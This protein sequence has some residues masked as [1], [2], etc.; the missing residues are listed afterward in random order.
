MTL[1]QLRARLAVGEASV[2]DLR[3][4]LGEVA[5]QDALELIVKGA[6]SL[7]RV[8]ERL[9]SFTTDYH[10]A[11][12]PSIR[13]QLNALQVLMGEVRERLVAFLEPDGSLSP[14]TPFDVIR[15]LDDATGY[16][17]TEL[18]DLDFNIDVDHVRQ[19]LIRSGAT[20]FRATLE[21]EGADPEE[22]A[23]FEEWI[24]Q[25]GGTLTVTVAPAS[26]VP[27]ELERYADV[28]ELVASLPEY[29]SLVSTIRRAAVL[30][31]VLL[32]DAGSLLDWGKRVA[33]P[34]TLFVMQGYAR[35]G[36]GAHHRQTQT[37]LALGWAVQ[38][39]RE[40]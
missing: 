40:V 2:G 3:R 14:L 22:Q 18:V 13:L 24:E 1:P 30:T 38:A 15:L 16:V 36:A 37:R 31:D 4:A 33:A 23:A 5:T 11:L 9:A 27:S 26:N 7:A 19:L 20:S 25:T 39:L 35:E 32:A 10:A 8:R 6:A 21:A 12:P 29:G 28:L 17:F 34:V